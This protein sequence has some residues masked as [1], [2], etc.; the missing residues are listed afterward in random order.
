MLQKEPLNIA[1][2]KGKLLPPSIRLFRKIGF[3]PPD[4]KDEDR[5]LIFEDPASNVRF[6]IIRPADVATYV[7]YG[8]ADLGIVGR[9]MLLEYENDLYEL[10]DLHFGHCKIVVAGPEDIHDIYRDG[11][12]YKL[13][14]A[15]KYP[16]ITEDFFARKGLEVEV[17][18]L[19]GSM[20]LAPLV[21][22]SHIIVDLISTG[23]TLQENNLSVIEVIAESTAKLVAN[24]ASLKLKFERIYDIVTRLEKVIKRKV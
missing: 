15:T 8:A 18:K 23:R 16:R 13:R 14:V 12:W 24:R 7:E 5:R 11:R 1:L 2:S 4:I 22:L 19:Y 10:L 21:G 9:D 3:Y 20:E 6:L 17:I